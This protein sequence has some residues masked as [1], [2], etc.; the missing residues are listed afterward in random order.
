[1]KKFCKD[2]TPGL[3]FGQNRRI[4]MGER[5]RRAENVLS[6]IISELP[7]DPKE[8]VQFERQSKLRAYI[9]KLKDDERSK[10]CGAFVY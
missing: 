3:T 5:R 10:Q 7:R 8:Q 1:M 6:R 4:D 2:F 9:R